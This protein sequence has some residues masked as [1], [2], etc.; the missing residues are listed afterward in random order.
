VPIRR[1]H[2]AL[3]KAVRIALDR[4][5]RD[6]GVDAL[7]DLVGDRLR[8]RE[9]TGD[10]ELGAVLALPALLEGREKRLLHDVLHHGEAV[11]RELGV[12][13]VLG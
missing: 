1:D 11:H 9:G 5:D 10:V 3:A 2:A 13:R 7:Q 4:E 8:A 12:S 6:V